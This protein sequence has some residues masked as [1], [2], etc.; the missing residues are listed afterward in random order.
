MPSDV[1]GTVREIKVKPGDKVKVG[2]L[3]LTLDDGCRSAGARRPQPDGERRDEAR[4]SRAAADQ[5]AVPPRTA[6]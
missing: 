5:P 6:A 2:Q 1:A 3:V 4:S